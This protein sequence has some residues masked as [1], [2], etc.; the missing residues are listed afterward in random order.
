MIARTV[1][2]DASYSTTCSTKMVHNRHR[3]AFLTDIEGI[4]LSSNNFL[5]FYVKDIFVTSLK[6]LSIQRKSLLTVY[7]IPT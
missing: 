1:I 7:I 3:R 5:K 2:V 6:M 4:F